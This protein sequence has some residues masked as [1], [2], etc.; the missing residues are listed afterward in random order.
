MHLADSLKYIFLIT[1]AL[2][3]LIFRIP[4]IALVIAWYVLLSALTQQQTNPKIE[5]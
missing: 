3:L 1:S 4:G 2:L 5:G